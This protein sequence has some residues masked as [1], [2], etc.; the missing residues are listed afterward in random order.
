MVVCLLISAFFIQTKAAASS[1]INKTNFDVCKVKK[2]NA[3][4]FISAT[5]K[6]V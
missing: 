6:T 2:N 4:F 5:E 3:A 1:E